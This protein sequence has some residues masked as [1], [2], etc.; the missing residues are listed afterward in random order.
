[1]RPGVIIILLSLVLLGFGERRADFSGKWS[2]NLR[3][4]KNLP[5]SFK[6]VKSYSMDVEQAGDSIVVAV[7]FEGG[8]Q[9]IQL[10]QTIY[11]FDGKER[12]REDT[13]RMS[14]RWISSG[15]TTTGQKLIVTSRVIQRQGGERRYK[16]TDIWELTNRNT[17]RV[18]VTQEF[19]GNDSTYSEQRLFHRSAD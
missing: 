5:S 10:P 8:G 9:R 15:W 13:V 19:E 12:Y 2:L 4:S 16:E 11:A 1:M 3:K 14:K 18:H 17:L 6:N 7:V